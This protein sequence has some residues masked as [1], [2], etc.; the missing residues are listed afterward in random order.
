MRL[1]CYDY[2]LT[3]L[4]YNPKSTAMMKK[5]LLAKG[6]DLTEVER[7]ISKLE[8]QSYLDDEAFCKAYFQSEVIN[9]WK[10]I[11]AIKKK[12]YEKWIPK[13]II[14]E[15]LEELAED[16]DDTLMANL[17]K[18]IRSLHSKWHDIIKIYEKLARKWHRYDDI[19][20]ALQYMNDNGR[21]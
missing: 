7:T 10:S 4:S 20:W 9:K 6:Y 19:K 8:S 11:N 21:E 12:M 5:T 14:T 18:E 1:P 3:L 17:A 2:A 16:I 15:T 13:E